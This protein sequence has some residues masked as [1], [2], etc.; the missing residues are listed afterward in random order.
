MNY[1]ATYYIGF[2]DKDT[3]KQEHN[4]YELAKIINDIMELAKI[5]SYTSS[6]VIGHYNGEIEHT[7]KLELVDMKLP[8]HSINLIKEKLNQECILEVITPCE[9]KFL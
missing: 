4:G 7:Y 9:Y 5:E 8:T 3:H 1:I 6:T 2:N